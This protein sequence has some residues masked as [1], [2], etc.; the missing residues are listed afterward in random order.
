MLSPVSQFKS[1]NE[2]QSI[3]SNRTDIEIKEEL[4]MYI[5][6]SNSKAK[7][8]S[9]PILSCSPQ[10]LKP[11]INK[12]NIREEIRNSKTSVKY[13]KEFKKAMKLQET[14]LKTD[15]KK[16]EVVKENFFSLQK[17]KRI[18]KKTV[19]YFKRNFLDGIGKRN[20]TR[21]NGDRISQ[22]A[23]RKSSLKNSQNYRNSQITDKTQ[24]K[25][26]SKNLKKIASQAKFLRSRK[27]S[28]QAQNSGIFTLGNTLNDLIE[29]KESS[30]K[31]INQFRA[32]TG[33]KISNEKKR[34]SMGF[35]EVLAKLKIQKCN[36]ILKFR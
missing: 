8:K 20:K 23:S 11:L 7:I 22:F 12:T 32:S 31:K 10:K 25:N 5:Q 4:E 6:M 28:N 14:L 33:F 17:K 27:Y 36:L 9:I 15:K 34:K 18:D 24:R 3:L 19:R 29:G 13:A 35:I 21:V 30:M 16:N 26:N 2:T 1:K